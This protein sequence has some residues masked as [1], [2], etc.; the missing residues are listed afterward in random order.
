V[1]TAKARVQECLLDWRPSAAGS[2]ISNATVTCRTVRHDSTRSS[3]R[4]GKSVNRALGSCPS[5]SILT[6]ASNSTP[7][8]PGSLRRFM[9]SGLPGNPQ[10]PPPETG[11]GAHWATADACNRGADLNWH[12]SSGAGR[13][14]TAHEFPNAA[15]PDGRRSAPR[16]VCGGPIGNLSVRIMSC[17]RPRGEAFDEARRRIWRYRCNPMETDLEWR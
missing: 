3:A 17:W 15:P 8:S 11:R 5:P 13:D 4:R 9:V 2:Q 1:G 10:P 14:A 6:E 16:R 12:R 7:A